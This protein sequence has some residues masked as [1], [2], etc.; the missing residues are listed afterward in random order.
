MESINALVNQLFEQPIDPNELRK[1]WNMD[2]PWQST[3]VLE[4]LNIITGKLMYRQAMYRESRF[5]GFKLKHHYID[6]FNMHWLCNEKPKKSRGTLLLLHGL[7]AEKA[8]WIRFA[9]YFIKDYHIIIPDLAAHGQTGYQP[10]A[11]Y[12]THAQAS[13]IIELLDHLQLDQVHVLGN[14]MGGFVCARLATSWPERIASL[15]LM[16]AAGLQARTYSSLV[17]SIESGC[18]PFLLHSLAEFDHLM[19]LAAYKQQWMPSQVRLMLAKQYSDRRERLFNVFLQVQNE[20]Y[21][22]DWVSQELPSINMATLVLWG[23]LDKLLD[24]DMLAHFKELIPHAKTVSMPKTG[25][26]PM[27]ERPLASARHYREFLKTISV[28]NNV[29][30]Q[31]AS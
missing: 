19:A 31:K 15:G 9:R 13:R 16:D 4:P 25:H 30:Q 11:N 17:E 6:G 26:M 7:S 22:H 5:Y 28:A 1:R 3:G 10:D 2:A 8:H 24:I 21:P 29:F 27:M 14:S 18:N 20:I 12:G 23:E